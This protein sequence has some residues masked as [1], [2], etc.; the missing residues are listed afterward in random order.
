MSGASEGLQL[1]DAATAVIQG[2]VAGP[3]EV[4]AQLLPDHQRTVRTDPHQ[5]GGEPHPGPGRQEAARHPR[6]VAEAEAGA[7]GVALQ[8]SASGKERNRLIG[9]VGLAGPRTGDD[10]EGAAV[11]TVGDPVVA[12]GTRNRIEQGQCQGHPRRIAAHLPELRQGGDLLQPVEADHPQPAGRLGQGQPTA[13]DEPSLDAV[14]IGPHPHSNA[15]PQYRR[16]RRRQL[17]R[18]QR[19][20]HPGPGVGSPATEVLLGDGGRALRQGRCGQGE[21][22]SQGRPGAQN[23]GTER[24]SHAHDPRKDPL[25]VNAAILNADA[26]VRMTAVICLGEALIDRLEPWGGHPGQDCLGGAPTNVACA[27][28]RLG[29]PA[30]LIS[31]LGDDAAGAAL[32]SCCAGRG[33]DLRGLQHDPIRPTRIVLVTRD[34]QG[35]RCF[36]GF[37]GDRGE[38]FADQALDAAALSPDL[39]AQGGWLLIGSI[40][41]A[42]PASAAAL[43]RAVALQHDHGGRVVLDVNWRPSFWPVAA[44]GARER[45]QPLL[46]Q[47]QLLKLA[48]EE[49][50]WLFGSTDPQQVA[51]RLPQHPGVVI[52]D[53][54]HG[55]AWWLDGSAGRRNAP[56]VP[57]TDTTGAGDAFLAG[58]LHGLLQG[59]RRAGDAATVEEAMAFACACGSIV[60]TG[61]GA[62]EPQPDAA[63]V[64][65]FLADGT[66]PAVIPAPHE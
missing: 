48:A 29:T 32:R 57:V 4:G 8:L 17:G 18:S 49:A 58:L 47:V 37:S 44:D 53:G 7:I 2:A 65:R 1:P 46:Q 40:P 45:L 52:T 56:V 12:A 66:L 11:A 5:S 54:G 25:L 51:L 64:Q 9:A 16:L 39:F 33:V 31:R 10:L 63:G 22:Q 24:Q 59:E 38:G 62:I 36:G 41:L 50:E 55:V 15:A 6:T 19:Q 60:C 42:S 26:R 21:H 23:C 20:Q 27:L 35:D 34:A 61:P 13:G 43:Q 28:A 3:P 30:T 14:P